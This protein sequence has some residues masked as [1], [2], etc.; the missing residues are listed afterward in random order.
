[1]GSMR[2]FVADRRTDGL[3]DGAGFI[4]TRASPKK[5][6]KIRTEN[7]EKKICRTIRDLLASPMEEFI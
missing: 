3:T 5:K 4:R 6:M 2:T 7:L 1:M